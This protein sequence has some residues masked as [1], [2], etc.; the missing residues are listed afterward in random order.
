MK[1]NSFLVVCALL[2][3]LFLFAQ[4]RQPLPIK[5]EFR[6][7]ID[8]THAVSEKSPN[9]EGTEKSPFEAKQLGHIDKDGY[10]SRYISL[11]EHFSTHIDAPAHFKSG[12]WTVDRIPPEHLIAPLAVLDVSKKVAGNPEYEIG[13][14]DI[15]GWEQQHGHIPPAA[16]VIARTGWSERWGSMKSYRNADDQGMH[17]PGFSE[18]AAKFLV[19]ARQV[20]GLGIDTLSVDPGVSKNYPVH[21]YV[22]AHNVYNL[23]N[24]ADLGQV[25]ASGAILIVAPAKLEG[26]S[27]G[28]VRLFALL[29]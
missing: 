5:S 9:W 13:M 8:L 4:R 26:G 1:W 14:E 23:E 7:A 10:F 16:V 24:V 2:V 3:T 22:A 27:G 19:D 20:S 28:P 12:A 6:A 25:P 21:Q 18:Q 11:P 17:F 15:A 29:H